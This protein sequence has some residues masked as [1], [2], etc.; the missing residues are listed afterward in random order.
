MGG[1]GGGGASKCH[2]HNN[3]DD[4]DK[5]SGQ[6]EIILKTITSGKTQAKAK[7]KE[8]RSGPR[9]QVAKLKSHSSKS[10]P[11][12]ASHQKSAATISIGQMLDK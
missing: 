9:A 5:S 11:L 7:R 12:V 6:V 2:P 4:D 3:N 1:G 8:K 10:T